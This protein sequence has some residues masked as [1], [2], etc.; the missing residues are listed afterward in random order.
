[1]LVKEILVDEE[2][3]LTKSVCFFFT[4]RKE[5]NSSGNYTKCDYPEKASS[6]KHGN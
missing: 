5:Q 6:F 2:G 4:S 1:V 3:R